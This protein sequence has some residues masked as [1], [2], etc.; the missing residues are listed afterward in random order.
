MGCPPD[1]D[2][3]APDLGEELH[4]ARTLLG[5][6]QRL[7][8]DGVQPLA[9]RA[10][11][12]RLLLR[13]RR[14][15]AAVSLAGSGLVACSCCCASELRLSSAA[16]AAGS[17]RWLRGSAGACLLLLLAVAV[18][19]GG[20]GSARIGFCHLNVT[21]ICLLLLLVALCLVFTALVLAVTGARWRGRGG[22][23]GA[24]AALL[25]AACAA[26]PGGAACLPAFALALGGPG[27]VSQV[28]PVLLEQE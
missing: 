28:L 9:P 23:G 14:R 20:W 3:P 5:S 18:R 16:L 19:N 11:V 8:D 13:G 24:A 17:C 15:L 12:A 1:L 10:A 26:L 27:A 22:G 6:S 4:P 2:A 25:A 21:S 7:T